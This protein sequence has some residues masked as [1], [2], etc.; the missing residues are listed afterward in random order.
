MSH[1]SPAA[2][3]VDRLIALT[4]RERE[5]LGYLRLGYTNAQIAC[6]LGS[7]ER[8]VRNQLS[9]VYEKLGVATRAEAAVRCDRV[10]AGD[11]A[12]TRPLTR[13]PGRYAWDDRPM[14]MGWVQL[15]CCVPCV[16]PL[17]TSMS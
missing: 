13:S 4:P 2:T 12:R 17:R 1:A 9:S 8:T 3:G 11:V 16:A 5:V 6:A 7:A 14:A 10:R 15:G